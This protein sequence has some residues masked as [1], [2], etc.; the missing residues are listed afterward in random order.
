MSSQYHNALF[1]GDVAE[2]V[3][4]LKAVG[5]GTQSHDLALTSFSVLL[6]AVPPV[7]SPLACSL[8]SLAYL[9][10][11]THGLS[12]EAGAIAETLSTRL[13]KASGLLLLWCGGEMLFASCSCLRCILTPSCCSPLP[14]SCRLSPTGPCSLWPRASSRAWLPK[15]RA[16][17]EV[18]ESMTLCLSV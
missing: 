13:D 7:T 18:R 1:T 2:R 8:D 15:V 14:P 11:A 17:G 16:G 4:I 3:K 6:S 5:Q 12:E 9:T 10:A